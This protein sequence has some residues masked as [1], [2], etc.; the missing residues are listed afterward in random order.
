[1]PLWGR[2]HDLLRFIAGELHQRQSSSSITIPPS[3]PTAPRNREEALN[4]WRRNPHHVPFY[5]SNETAATW[6]CDGSHMNDW[7]MIDVETGQPV[8]CRLTMPSSTA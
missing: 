3:S 1:M 4:I 6:Q 8:Y 7:R 5:P 2:V